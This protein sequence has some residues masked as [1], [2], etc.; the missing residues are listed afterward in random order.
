MGICYLGVPSALR[1]HA[2]VGLFAPSPVG[3]STAIPNATNV[4]NFLGLDAIRK[5]SIE[6]EMSV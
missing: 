5:D 1:C 6:R 3:L 4:L 2:A